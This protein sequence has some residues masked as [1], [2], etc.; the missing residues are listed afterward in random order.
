M[1]YLGDSVKNLYNKLFI[2]FICLTIFVVALILINKLNIV[3][4]KTNKYI[5]DSN[6]T[7]DIINKDG[8]NSDSKIYV[9]DLVDKIKVNFTSKYS[10]SKNSNIK[11]RYEIISYVI[12]NIDDNTLEETEVYRKK[13]ILKQSNTINSAS[14][15]IDINE[16]FDLNYDYYNN[17]ATEYDKSVNLALKSRLL[18]ELNL[19]I[20]LENQE[21]QKYTSTLSLPLEK[22]T[23]SITKNENNSSGSFFSDN[24]NK[25]FV[26]A[27]F[28]GFT[29]IFLVLIISEINRINK[30]KKEHVLEFKYKK[31]MQD[32]NNI[33]VP[34]NKIPKDKNLV[35]VKVLYFKSMID[36]QKELHMPILCY[37]GEKLVVY[38][39][40]HEKLAYVYFLND[41]NE[42][43]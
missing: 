16:L 15:N 43:I 6:I 27:L 22:S 21:E 17:I 7:Y 33:V 13:E 42:K 34:I 8:T 19:Y 25:L 32:Y 24:N 36:I 1:K 18:V 41:N 14:N 26:N 5:L 2:Y 4:S 28:I 29:F 39:I 20:T 3:K 38:M 23:F 31:I 35:T 9:S 12:S 11:Y 30:Y 10:L 37:E 40:I